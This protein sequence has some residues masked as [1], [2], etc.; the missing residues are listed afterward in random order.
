[1]KILLIEDDREMADG[2]AQTLRGHGHEVEISGTGTD[3]AT[4]ARSDGFAALIV[5]RML[6]GLDGLTLVRELRTDGINTPVLFLTTM[7]GIDDRVQGLEGGADDY[8]TKPFAAAELL[9]RVHA[10]TRRADLR[11]ETTL[12]KGAGLEMNLIRRTVTRAGHPVTLQAQ[13]F[14]LLEYLLRNVDKVVTRTMLLEHVWELHFDPRTNIVETHM[15]RLRA[16]L[17]CGLGG[18]IISTVRG[19]GYI[20]RAH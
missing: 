17:D 9:A 16:K 3:G 11:G 19:T 12:L 18:E 2:I 1:M 10:I 5:D 7:S 4:R 8:L 15:S 20:L 6:P 14:L 13:E